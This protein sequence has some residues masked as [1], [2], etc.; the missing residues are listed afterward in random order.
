MVH[1][2]LMLYKKHGKDTNPSLSAKELEEAYKKFLHSMDKLATHR[3][4][5]YHFEAMLTQ[6]AAKGMYENHKYSELSLTK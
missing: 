5:G 2:V 4:K 6:W 3:L 1:F